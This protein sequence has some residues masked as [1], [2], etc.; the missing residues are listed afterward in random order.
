MSIGPA[1]AA[2][3]A[4]ATP[5]AS[6]NLSTILALIVPA[7]TIVGVIVLLALKS[8]DQAAGLALIGAIAGVHGGAAVANASGA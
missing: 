6:A 5:K 4:A 8:I 2:P 7:V 3:P 1:A